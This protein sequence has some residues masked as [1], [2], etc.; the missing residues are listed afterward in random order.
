MSKL[1]KNLK[2]QRLNNFPN[3]LNSLNL[4]VKPLILDHPYRHIRVGNID[5]WPATETIYNRKSRLKSKGLELFKKLAQEQVNE[6][7]N[8]F[9]VRKKEQPNWLNLL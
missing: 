4:K 2:I 9:I 5:Y 8:N 3:I 6:K 1:D 7:S